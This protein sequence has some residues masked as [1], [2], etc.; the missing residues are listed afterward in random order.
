MPGTKPE[1]KP[2]VQPV[3]EK[4]KTDAEWIKKKW[5]EYRA[6]KAGGKDAEASKILDEILKAQEKPK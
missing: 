5:N 2:P 6:L 3:V 1:I 4:P